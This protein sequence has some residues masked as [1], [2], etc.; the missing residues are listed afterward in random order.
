M[1]FHPIL[2][3]A[4]SPVSLIYRAGLFF[5]NWGYQSGLLIKK[6]LPVPVISIGNLSLG[7]TGKTPCAIYLAAKARERG[8]SPAILTR[9]YGGQAR[10]AVIVSD[11]VNLRLGPVMA[12][13]EACLMGK[14]AAGVPVIKSPDRYAGGLLAIE[15]F[16]SNIFILDDGFQHIRVERDVDIVLISA[17]TDLHSERL[18]PAGQLREPLSALGRAHEIILTKSGQRDEERWKAELGHLGIEGRISFMTYEPAVLVDSAGNTWSLEKLVNR[19]VLAFS[20]IADPDHFER[21]LVDAG[22]DVVESVR[23]GDH[24]G[25]VPGELETIRKKVVETGAEM[26]MT[27]EKDMVKLEG[28]NSDGILALR[29]RVSL[30]DAA[31]ERIFHSASRRLNE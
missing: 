26:I 24:H 14:R 10:G 25:Y 18:F 13:D 12:G 4:L 21:S 8:Y 3:A 9:G 20:G 16:N 27:T 1:R 2:S 6:R 29:A 30:E 31:L 22:A 23:F 19:R 17:S 7:G 5:R 15:S 11:G 28:Y